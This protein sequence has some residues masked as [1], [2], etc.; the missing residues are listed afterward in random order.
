VIRRPAR[1]ALRLVALRC[2]GPV[3]A[4]LGGVARRRRPRVPPGHAGS[5]RILLIRPDHLGD[6]L[7]AAPVAAV[8]RAALPTARIDWLVGPW[9]AEVVR[10][11]G[12]DGE[13]FELPFPGFTRAPKTSVA[14]PYR[15]LVREAAG[16]RARR[17]DA[18]LVL[19]PDHWWGATLAAAAGV[20]R[21]FGYAVAECTPFLTDTL[22]LPA[23][24]QRHAVAANQ[25]LAGLAIARLAGEP[26]V[27]PLLNPAFPLT[28]GD[29]QWAR[30][31]MT[32]QA[33]V[34]GAYG[35]LVV[36]HAGSGAV[37]KNWPAERWAAVARE[38]RA[39]AQARV[40]LTGGPTEGELVGAVAV[41][42]DPSPPAL[43]GATTLGQLGALFAAADLVL[44]GDSGPLHLAAAVGTPTVRVYGPTDTAEFGPW[45]PSPQQIAVSSGLAC[46]PCRAIVNPPCGAVERPACLDAVAPAAVASLALTLLTAGSTTGHPEP[47]APPGGP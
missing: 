4:A 34:A 21:R 13:V 6:L 23:G 31:W 1:A 43:V 44:G 47:V 24:R 27:R 5:P 2:V 18:A 19:R 10:R 32:R 30:D 11:C 28:A 40:V 26:G 17:Y 20:P 16:L 41:L 46:Q 37:L 35:P 8:L 33:R 45:P 7:L 3:V 29:Q 25:A 39:S 12:G 22:P 14:A 36:I 38:L 15:L 42:L 9:S